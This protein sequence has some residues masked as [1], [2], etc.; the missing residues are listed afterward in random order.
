MP[1]LSPLATDLARA[2]DPTRV[3]LDAGME[4][5]PWQGDLLRSE[6]DRVL[7]LC[8]RQAGKSTTTAALAVNTALTDP[9]L[10]LLVAPAQRQ[11]VELFRKTKELLL[12]QPDAPQLEFESAM[13]MELANDSRVVALPG[14]E[15]TIRGFSSPKL[16]VVDEAARVDDELFTA[17][18]PMLA[19]G[20]GRM[21]LLTT[22]W[23]KRGWFYRAWTEGKGWER[24]RITA[25]QCP[26]IR[27]DWLE[28]ERNTIGEWRYRQE[29]ECEFVDST[30]S[31]FSSQLV[32]AALR[33]CGGALWT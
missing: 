8:S 9:G 28:E 20:N 27:K 2:L 6:S 15:A 13:R 22:P 3:M 25:E 32:E 26:R 23:G 1:S 16:I 10:V 11:S 14:S 24:I 21:I 30:E 18:R 7:L 5:D 33:P 4:P 17:L 19:T 29:F 12:K 31:P